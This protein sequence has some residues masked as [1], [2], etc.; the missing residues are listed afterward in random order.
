MVEE[1]SAAS[2]LTRKLLVNQEPAHRKSC[3]KQVEQNIPE[4]RAPCANVLPAIK[5][6]AARN[7][8]RFFFVILH[9]L[10]L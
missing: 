10:C 2:A 7:E 6:V 5:N 9:I 8:I 4:V 3:E 1:A